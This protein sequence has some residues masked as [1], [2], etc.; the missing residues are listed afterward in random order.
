MGIVS[1]E[2]ITYLSEIKGFNEKDEREAGPM[3]KT[4]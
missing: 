3:K 2:K 4:K 1:A